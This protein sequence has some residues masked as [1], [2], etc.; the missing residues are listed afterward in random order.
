MPI[1]GAVAKWDVR[2]SRLGLFALALAALACNV[3]GTAQPAGPSIS[4]FEDE[5]E[6]SPTETLEPTPVPT[7]PPQATVTSTLL[8]DNFEGASRAQPL[9]GPE[10][11][12][13]TV[14]GGEGALT[15]LAPGGVV[16]VMY[17]APALAD[18]T[19]EVD[20]RFPQAQPESVAGIIF[21][22]DETTDGLAYYYHLA[23]RPAAAQ[24]SLDLW[25]D[26][27]WSTV[28]SASIGAAVL[29][30]GGA[31]RLRLEVQGNQFR[32]FANEVLIL[33]ATDAR[34]GEPG[35]FGLSLVASEAPETVY[36][37]NL[38]LEPPGD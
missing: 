9:F 35:I 38:R 25:K 26:G 1:A 32:L 11:M 29:D 21:R 22:S 36:F 33:E 7:A 5:T 24:T 14:E 17:P 37:D 16:P 28:T 30:P 13:F 4:P 8:L 2:V 19:A 18:F 34:L 10:F 31:N 23:F 12:S 6:V 15:S 20:V 27:A 3:G